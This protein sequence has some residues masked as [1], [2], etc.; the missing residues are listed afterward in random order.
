VHIPIRNTFA[1][2]AQTICENFDT[3]KPSIGT[4]FLKIII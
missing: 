2:L 4:S 1:D 3:E